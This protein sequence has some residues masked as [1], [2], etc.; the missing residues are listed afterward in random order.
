MPGTLQLL[1]GRAG[2]ACCCHHH[3]AHLK[4]WLCENA[5]P[6]TRWHSVLP[7][8]AEALQ[9]PMDYVQRV[10]RTHSQGGYGSQG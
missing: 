8:P 6:P 3:W 1:G 7:D 2:Y 10:K 9:L 4:K 5:R